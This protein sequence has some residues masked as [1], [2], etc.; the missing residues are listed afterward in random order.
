MSNL[1]SLDNVNDCN[2]CLSCDNLLLDNKYQCYSCKHY[3]CGAF[4]CITPT[5]KFRCTRKFLCCNQ[6]SPPIDFH[7]YNKQMFNNKK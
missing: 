5:F 1:N 2:K 4:E 3:F 6:C 7:R